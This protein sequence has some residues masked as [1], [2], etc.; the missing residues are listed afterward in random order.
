MSLQ[1]TPL[2]EAEMTVL[3]LLASFDQMIIPFM[4]TYACSLPDISNTSTPERAALNAAL[5]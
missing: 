1:F 4:P 5:L 3:M 2:W